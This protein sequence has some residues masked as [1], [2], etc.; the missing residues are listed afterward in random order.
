[1][2]KIKEILVDVKTWVFATVTTLIAA[3]SGWLDVIKDLF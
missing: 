1:M 2:K 3:F